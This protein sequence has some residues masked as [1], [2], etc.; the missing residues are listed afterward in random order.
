VNLESSATPLA[1]LLVLIV[2]KENML[3]PKGRALAKNALWALM[4]QQLVKPLALNALLVFF[5]I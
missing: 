5:K 2:L 1:Y 4:V 3:V